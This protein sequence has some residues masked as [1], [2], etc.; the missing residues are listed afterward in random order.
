MQF[1]FRN[2]ITPFGYLWFTLVR[3]IVPFGFL[4]GIINAI[5]ARRERREEERRLAREAEKAE[6]AARL[7]HA[8][9]ME[10]LRLE[11]Q[12]RAELVR[13]REELV[14]VIVP[15][16]IAALIVI[17]LIKGKKRKK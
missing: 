15:L 11:K 1:K 6:R 16:G 9:K 4:G 7:E 12:K 3:P 13:G 8:R 2:V 17:V 10:I 5:F 14:R